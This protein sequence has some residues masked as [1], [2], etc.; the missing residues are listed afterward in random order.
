MKLIRYKKWKF[1]K[2]DF[3][4]AYVIFILFLSLFIWDKWICKLLIGEQIICHTVH[5]GNESF[6]EILFLDILMPGLLSILIFIIL[7]I[8]VYMFTFGPF[9]SMAFGGNSDD[10]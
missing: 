3:I 7:F 9:I 4:L 2:E 8:V 10:D 1:S 5:N 6:I